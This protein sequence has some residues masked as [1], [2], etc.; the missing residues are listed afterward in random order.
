MEMNETK[1]RHIA[2]ALTGVLLDE[3]HEE[4]NLGLMEID[5]I[6]DIFEK[7]CDAL[8]KK[9]LKALAMVR[10]DSF[11]NAMNHA[12]AIDELMS[13]TPSDEKIED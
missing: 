10:P 4:P 3:D 9:E 7:I 2:F 6:S 5:R 11:V 13:D 1:R 12:K 8:D